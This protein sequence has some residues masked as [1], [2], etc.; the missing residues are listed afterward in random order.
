M[1]AEPGKPAQYFECIAVDFDGDNHAGIYPDKIKY[2]NSNP[3]FAKCANGMSQGVHLD[4]VA[5]TL[6]SNNLPVLVN[7]KKLSGFSTQ[8]N[9]DQWWIGGGSTLTF[10]VALK[11]EQDLNTK[12]WSHKITP[13]HPLT[14]KGFDKGN[15]VPGHVASHFA[16]HCESEFIYT[17]GETFTFRGD[18]DVWIFINYKLAV[19][20]GG[21]HTPKEKTINVDTL[22]LIK[23]CRYP[24]HLFQADRCATGSNFDFETSLTPV[25]ETEKGGICPNSLAPGKFCTNDNQCKQSGGGSYFC[26][27]DPTTTLGKCTA[28]TRAGGVDPS[29]AGTGTNGGGGVSSSITPSSN[30]NSNSNST[31]GMDGLS[32]DKIGMIVGIALGSVLLVVLVVFVI[33]WLVKRSKQEN[34]QHHELRPTSGAKTIV[35]AMEMSGGIRKGGHARKSTFAG[36]IKHVDQDSQRYYYQNETNGETRWGDKVAATMVDNPARQK[37]SC[38]TPKT[39]DWIEHY[40]ET[41]GK[42]FYHNE[43]TGETTWERPRTKGGAPLA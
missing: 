40:D 3:D 34:N 23:G 8:A 35:Q 37:T 30:S 10:S 13:F 16:I 41:Y 25:R 26:Y 11:L 20:L 36:W 28:G 39:S 14:G 43:K 4:V 27:E 15:V 38:A 32:G 42:S 29:Q 17:G 19:D 2:T 7:P 6:G 21:L 22:G 1:A 9:F 31:A 5:S 33:M 18:D 12:I 24:I